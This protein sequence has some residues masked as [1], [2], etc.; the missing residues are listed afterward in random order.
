MSAP[1][2]VDGSELAD[3]LSEVEAAIAQREREHIDE[4]VA[5]PEVDAA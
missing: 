4:A 2:G 1:I 5:A 3:I